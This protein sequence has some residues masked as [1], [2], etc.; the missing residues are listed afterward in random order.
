MVDE[1]FSCESSGIWELGANPDD[2]MIKYITI[3]APSRVKSDPQRPR[4]VIVVHKR[5]SVRVGRAH[6]MQQEHH[7]NGEDRY[8]FVTQDL[9]TN[10]LCSAA[11]L[12]LQK[13]LLLN[14]ALVDINEE[15]EPRAANQTEGEQEIERTAVVS[16][17]VD[18]CTAHQ[19]TNEGTGLADDREQTEEQELLASWR[20]LTDHS[21][22]VAVPGTDE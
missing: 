6:W 11:L 19:R 16:G 3:K 12:L 13:V 5:K 8:V 17:V 2:S 10:D 1:D 9:N 22:R 15:V 20:D 14:S 18:D 21:L 4:F 7:S